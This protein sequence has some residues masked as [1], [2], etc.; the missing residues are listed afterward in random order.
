MQKEAFS[1]LQNAGFTT[2]FAGEEDHIY[3][4]EITGADLIVT[5]VLP[6]NELPATASGATLLY[7]CNTHAIE[8]ERR[9]HIA[10]KK[11][12]LPLEPESSRGTREQNLLAYERSDYLLIAEN[13]LGVKNF[14][15]NGVPE[16]KIKRYNNCVDIGIWTPG[17][18]KRSK[19]TYVCYASALGIRKGLPALIEAWKN[20]YAGQDAELF[21]LGT[22]TIVSDI[23]LGCRK[24]S[25][26]SGIHIDLQTYPAQFKPLI[27]F[28]KSCHIAVLPTL[29]DAQPS[30]LLEM[31]ACGL[32]V[33]TTT[34]SGV[35]FE[36]EFC[37]YVKPNSIEDLCEAFESW[38]ERRDRIQDFGIKARMF[39]ENNHSWPIFRRHFRDIILKVALEW[40]IM[41][42]AN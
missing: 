4:K 38:Y 23:L 39:I 33:I 20:W 11:W 5:V 1:C 28:L 10:S 21:L 12:D 19:F 34:E 17:D 41:L 9:L 27:E 37:I 31:T 7:T 15:S 13:D 8:R 25:P 36:N 40:G 35:E 16:N 6:M 32:P 22:P 18:L 24:G 3:P 26:F 2:Y 14:L 30:S 42:S 29:E